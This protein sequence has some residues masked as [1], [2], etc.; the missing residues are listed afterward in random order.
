MPRQRDGR[1]RFISA[2]TEPEVPGSFGEPGD[3]SGEEST[4]QG[5]GLDQ[6]ESSNVTA[7]DVERREESDPVSTGHGHQAVGILRG[8]EAA[9]RSGQAVGTGRGSETT[10]I[11]S[12]TAVGVRGGEATGS[13]GTAGREEHREEQDSAST[14]CGGEAVG[15]AGMAGDNDIPAFDVVATKKLAQ[16]ETQ[17]LCKENVGVWKSEHEDFL[18]LQNCWSAVQLTCKWKDRPGQLAKLLEDKQW[19]AANTAA[20]L[21]LTQ[22]IRQEDKAFL[23]KE[24]ISGRVWTFLMEKYK[25]R[26]WVDVVNAVQRVAL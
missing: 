8:S 12:S 24:R 13:A 26:M 18:R 22:N 1:G 11:H 10:G 4:N 3:G 23:K 19:S 5:E 2:S 20:K 15:S 16:F 25:R 17:T 7:R 14:V 9:G 21:Y 6:G